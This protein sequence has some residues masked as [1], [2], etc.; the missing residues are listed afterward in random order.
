MPT[1]KTHYLSGSWYPFPPPLFRQDSLSPLR[2]RYLDYAG[3]SRR[4]GRAQARL[5]SSQFP[6]KDVKESRI[7][8]GP[9]EITI[10]DCTTEVPVSVE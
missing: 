4:S 10:Y 9:R 1:S 8:F 6:V 2:W 7:A 5:F 3:C